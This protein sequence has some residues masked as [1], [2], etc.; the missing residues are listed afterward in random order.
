MWS[1][2]KL[3]IFF[4]I[5]SL[6]FR[7][8]SKIIISHFCKHIQLLCLKK[9]ISEWTG[10][11]RKSL[12]ANQWRMNIYEKFF[13]KMWFLCKKDCFFFDTRIAFYFHCAK[14]AKKELSVRINSPFKVILKHLLVIPSYTFFAFCSVIFLYI[15]WNILL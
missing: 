15:F 10:H 7:F 8:V 4:I 9:K 3:A 6:S 14:I 1:I 5:V 2:V 12:S 13:W 11:E